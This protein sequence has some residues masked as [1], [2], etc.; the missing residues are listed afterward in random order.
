MRL[1]TRLYTKILTNAGQRRYIAA[2]TPPRDWQV[3]HVQARNNRD[4]KGPDDKWNLRVACVGCNDKMATRNLYEFK[5]EGLDVN[6]AQFEWRDA[7]RARERTW[8]ET[9]QR[10]KRR[11][12]HNK[13]CARSKE[14]RKRAFFGYK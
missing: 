10:Y 11:L 9:K 6:G 14:A 1:T 12:K 4:W 13:Q 2:D 5:H 8:L 3:C 7:Q